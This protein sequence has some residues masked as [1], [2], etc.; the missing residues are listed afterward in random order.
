MSNLE[1]LLSN[2]KGSGIIVPPDV[3]KAM[4]KVDIEDFTDYD[5]SGFFHDRPV[6]FL[7]TAEGGVKTISAPHMI[8]TLL[9]NLE[10]EKGQHI[11]IYGAKGG[12]IS[13]LIAH[14]VGEEGRVTVLDP[15]GDVIEHI[16]NNL[17][18]YPTVNCQKITDFEKLSLPNLNRV[19]VTGQIE[20][21]P[22][23]LNDGLEDGGFTIAP[24]GDKNSQRLLKIEKQG[25]DLFETD[26]GSV[27]FGPLDI[28]DSVI[29]TPSPSE[30]A[31]FI[32]QVIELMKEAQIIEE[33]D[34]TKLYDLVAELR[35]L[36]DDLP[37][38]EE[39]DNPEEHPLLKLMVE[40]GE[41]FTRLW[42]IIQSIVQ[43]RIASYDSPSDF[44]E[45]SSHSDFIP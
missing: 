12:Y 31:E 37:P 42:P 19:L 15:S 11:V 17:R 6:V 8:V 20:K 34:K 26:L 43:T 23:W 39:V 33:E 30:M 9:H 38:P 36:P 5:S 7:E 3:E 14:V 1:K 25:E 16:S 28:A 45:G 18:G 24:I 40:K 27:V 44:E 13:A 2:L 10:L 21:L 22:D 35:Q 32:E 41:W 4:Y 29:E